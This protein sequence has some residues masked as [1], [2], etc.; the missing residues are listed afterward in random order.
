MRIDN[1]E[2]VLVRPETP[3]NVGSV[4]RACRNFG[5]SRLC[6]VGSAGIT[7]DR[8]ALATAHACEDL[9]ENARLVEH[10]E[11]ALRPHSFVVGTANRIRKPKLP[12]LQTP[13]QILPE[14]A[15]ATSQGTCAFLFGCES[16]GLTDVD[17]ARCSRL[18]RIPTAVDQPSLNLAQAVLS[19]AQDCWR[20]TQDLFPKPA[21]PHV[22]PAAPL[23]SALGAETPPQAPPVPPTIG[24]LELLLRHA[25][26]LMNKTGFRPYAG[27]PET[28]RLAARRSLGRGN[29]ERRD[30]RT[31]LTILKHL[32]RLEAP[33]P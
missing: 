16:R 33:Q 32:D 27:D 14:L 22:R 6:I 26:S 28:F 25:E 30:L 18:M 23:S 5:I 3:Q 7:T 10:T 24:E 13:V 4:A 2:I 31:F 1:I 15:T 19:V 8:A 9:L 29:F 21:H 11:E 12:P 20:W 17:L